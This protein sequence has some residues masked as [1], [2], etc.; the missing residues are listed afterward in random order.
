MNE[1]VESCIVLACPVVYLMGTIT[2]IVAYPFRA[3]WIQYLQLILTFWIG[4]WCAHPL[5]PRPIQTCVKRTIVLTI[6][7]SVTGVLVTMGMPLD[8]RWIMVLFH[9]L[10]ITV[11]FVS[12]LYYHLRYKAK[13]HGKKGGGD[14]TCRQWVRCIQSVD[15]AVLGVALWSSTLFTKKP[16]VLVIEYAVHF[17]VMTIGMYVQMETGSYRW[18][19][20]VDKVLPL[21]LDL[22]NIVVEYF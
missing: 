17:L 14:E 18:R 19:R 2:V 1:L 22:K 15:I 13:Y 7:V 4:V 3:V 12:V 21:P 5:S 9:E 6:L 11:K 20:A 16:V 10:V 8:T